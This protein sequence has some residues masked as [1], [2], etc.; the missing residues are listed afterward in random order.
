MPENKLSVIIPTINEEENLE[1]CFK[2]LVSQTWQYYEVIVADGGS[3]DNTV[4]IAGSCGFKVLDIEKTR[5]HHVSKA[6][7]F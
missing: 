1:Q 7:N 4:E 3:T 5:S 6:K 2:S